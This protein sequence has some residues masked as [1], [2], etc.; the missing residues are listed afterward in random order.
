MTPPVLRPTVDRRTVRISV[1]VGAVL[2]LAIMAAGIAFALIRPAA[3]TAEA[4]AV[5]LPAKGL[6]EA[7][8]A[9]QFETL[10]RGQI[11]ATFAEVAGNLRFQT[12]A[13]DQLNLTA[14]QRQQV[15]LEATVVPNTSVILVRVTAPDP[16][17]AE[18]MADA[19]TTLASQYLTGVLQPYRTETVQ[20]AQ[21][22]AT[23]SGLTPPLLIFASIVVGLVA[24]IAA[25][26]ALYHLLQVLRRAPA[27]D[28]SGVAPGDLPDPP[29][30]GHASGPAV[31]A[32]EPKRATVT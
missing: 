18:K 17:V 10:S 1:I 32:A 19:T 28:R 21:G 12:A 3:Y 15:Q 22:T 7:T 13:A 20:S 26:Q 16:A 29:A 5:V 27:T 6:D 24:G 2:A 4:M 8:S 11:P 30:V 25:Q 23:S 9:S 14:A 31:A